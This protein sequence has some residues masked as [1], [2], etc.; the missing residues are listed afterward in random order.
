MPRGNIMPTGAIGD[1]TPDLL[2][3]LFN[4]LLA[5]ISFGLAALGLEIDVQYVALVIGSTIAGSLLLGFYRPERTFVERLKKI[6]MASLAGL[7]FGSAIVSWRM[8]EMPAFI[9]LTY[10]MTSMLVLIFLRTLVG[11]TETNAGTLTTTLI[12]RIFNV[13][14][15]RKGDC[16]DEIHTTKGGTRR[17]RRRPRQGIHI[18]QSPDKKPVVV[19]DET[20]KPDEVRVIEETV[21]DTKKDK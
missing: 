14:L 21:V 2:M 18:S 7:I 8:I 16:D 11:L 13:K 4:L 20:A 1:H 12:Q 6:A 3:K 15:N 19:I 17:T 5:A 10:C 9:S